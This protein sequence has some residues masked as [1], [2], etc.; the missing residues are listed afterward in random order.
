MNRKK[1]FGDDVLRSEDVG[2]QAWLDGLVGLRVRNGWVW[3]D[4]PTARELA[5]RLLLHA[6]VADFSDPG[7]S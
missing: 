6:R 7:A 2:V 5:R 3:M 4:P 1:A